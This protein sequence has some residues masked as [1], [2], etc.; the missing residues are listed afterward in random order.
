MGVSYWYQTEACERHSLHRAIIGG[1]IPQDLT[2]PGYFSPY[3]RAWHVPDPRIASVFFVVVF[4]AVDVS[5]PMQRE[6]R[7]PGRRP[8]PKSAR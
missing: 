5:A 7:L 6:T 8:H 2:P 1:E 4:S 3:S